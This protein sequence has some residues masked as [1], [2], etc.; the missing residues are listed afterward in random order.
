MFSLAELRRAVRLLES[1]VAGARLERV[2]AGADEA[3]LG[4]VLPSGCLLVVAHPE[5][6]R[7][8][9]TAAP[10]PAARSVPPLGQ[11]LRAHA[12][13]ARLAGVALSGEE[14]QAAVRL[15]GGEVVELLL[16]ILGARTNLYLLDRERRLVLAARPLEKTRRD[17]Q[18]GDAWT[19][20]PG[21]PREGTDRWAHVPDERF[22]EAVEETYRAL[23][24]ERRAAVLERRIGQALGRELEFLAR[25][26]EN[27]QVDRADAAEADAWRRRGELLKGMLHEIRPGAA[28]ARARDFETGEEVV[29]ELDP[30]RSPADNLER[31]FD[32]YHRDLRRSDAVA[33]QIAEVGRTRAALETLAAELPAAR[34]A[35]PE[36]LEELAARPE[37]RRLLGR[38]SSEPKPR[39]PARPSAGRAASR[40]GVPGRLLP[41]R[42]RTS[43]GLEVWVGRNDEGNDYLTTRLARGNDLFLHLEASPGSHVVLRTEGRSDPPAESLLEACELAVHFSKAKNAGRADVH[44]AAIKNVRKPAGAKPGLVYV[45]RGRTVHL[46]RDAKRLERVLAS[47]LEE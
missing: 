6:A 23:E 19:D 29:I 8:S 22:F 16:S 34:D 20:P 27:L 28:E 13:R 35:G 7:L 46:R 9:F 40:G 32:R 10:P 25:K 30:A 41:K 2:V 3:T 11:F 37:L 42:F 31:I 5:L 36:A 26:A 1:R 18:P 44:V 14:R 4:L 45:S 21:A 47:R 24:R 15:E 12:H 17:L 33:A 43:D 39:A 38:H